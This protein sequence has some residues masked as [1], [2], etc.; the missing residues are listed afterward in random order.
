[1]NGYGVSW[2]Q[3]LRKLAFMCIFTV[4]PR[5][6]DGL[7]H[8]IVAA[9]SGGESPFLS[10]DAGVRCALRCVALIIRRFERPACTD[11]LRDWLRYVFANYCPA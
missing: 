9:S 3:I 7:L 2:V 4:L 11:F 8:S 1:M 5:L 10:R 6:A